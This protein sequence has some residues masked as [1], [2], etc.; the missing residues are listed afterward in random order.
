MPERSPS[1]FLE[2]LRA[3]KEFADRDKDRAVLPI[4]RR[5]LE[6]KRAD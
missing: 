6:L 5:T 2:Q 3:H 1:R 4:L